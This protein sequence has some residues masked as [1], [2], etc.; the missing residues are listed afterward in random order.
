MACLGVG[1]AWRNGQS[2]SLAAQWHGWLGWALFVAGW[3]QVAGALLRGSKGGPTDV[4]LRG[5]HY[6]MTPRRRA[7]ELVHKSL[8]WLALLLAVAVVFLGLVAVDAPRWM[9]LMLALWWVALGAAFLYLQS[10]GKCIDT[11]QA[12]WGPDPAHPGNRLPPSGWGV[13]RPLG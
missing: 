13:R 11:Y 2:A 10:R 7:F 8:G 9:L 1:L 12:I 5:D 6:D 3:A 4:Q